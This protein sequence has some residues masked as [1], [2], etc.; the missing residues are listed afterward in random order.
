MG[1]GPPGAKDPSIAGSFQMA[2][3]NGE[4]NAPVLK[5]SEP[6]VP[7]TDS[8]PNPPTPD[9]VGCGGNG[10]ERGGAGVLVLLREKRFGP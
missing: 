4:M 10:C 9:I 7:A 3:A 5:S 2:W 1:G 6:T 8:L